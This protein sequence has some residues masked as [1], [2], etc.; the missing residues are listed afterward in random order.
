MKNKRFPVYQATIVLLAISLFFLPSCEEDT[1]FGYE[2]IPGQDTLHGYFDSS[3]SLS[4][5]TFFQ[6]SI[7]SDEGIY[8]SARPYSVVGS[9]LDP[10]FG[11]TRADFMTEVRLSSNLVSFGDTMVPDS[12][13]LYLKLAETYGD[14]RQAVPTNISVYKLSSNIHFDSTYYSNIN[15]ANYH[16]PADL[17]GTYTYY[18]QSSDSLL[19]I[20]LDTTAFM[21]ILRTD[22]TMLNSDTFR[23]YM[24]GFYI[25]SEPVEQ[26]GQILSFDMLSTSSQLSLFYHYQ[27]DDDKP[28]LPV[29]STRRFNFLI[30]SSCA[31]IN[32][33]SHDYSKAWTPIQ[34]IGDSTFA[35]SKGYIQGLGGVKFKINTSGL[36]HW[37]DSAG[38]VIVKAELI[39]PIESNSNDFFDAP[40]ILAL[41]KLENDT[42]QFLSD[43]YHNGTYYTDYFNGNFYS[44]RGEYRFNIAQHLQDIISGASENL[45]LVL[46]PYATENPVRANRVIIDQSNIKL[47]VQYLK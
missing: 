36:E 11:F 12:L 20:A 10:V 21:N 31:R 27:E 24:P 47:H 26:G 4:G 14:F 2:L 1:S 25:T 45:S 19:R 7:R 37:K 15:P 18:P 28:I 8:S 38:L 34:G 30:N 22:S 33:L 5:Y 29:S 13:V 3:S 44:T 40:S 23:V 9:Y 35:T 43:Q 46:Y 17:V 42:N 6:D 41:S 32:H 16:N 39:I